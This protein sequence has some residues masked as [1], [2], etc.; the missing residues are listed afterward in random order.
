M[1]L[2]KVRQPISRSYM[3]FGG[4]SAGAGAGSSLASVICERSHVLLVGK[5]CSRNSNCQADSVYAV[6]DSCCITVLHIRTHG[7]EHFSLN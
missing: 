6:W 7:N 1:G 4:Y 2:R 5:T 3:Y